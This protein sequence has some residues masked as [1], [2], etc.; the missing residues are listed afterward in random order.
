M[1]FTFKEFVKTIS[2]YRRYYAQEITTESYFGFPIEPIL[3]VEERLQSLESSTVAYLSMEFALAAGHYNSMHGS[4]LFEVANRMEPRDVVS[5]QMQTDQIVQLTID[6]RKDLPIYSGGLGVLAGDVIK[7]AADLKLPFV[8]V[9]LLWRKGFFR[10]KIRFEHGQTVEDELWD[11]RRYPGLIALKD[12]ITIESQ[13]GPI[14][15]RLWKYYVYSRDRQHACPLILLDTYIPQSDPDLKK[16]TDQLYRSDH[17]WW[18][19]A[20]R[21]VLG[22][23][24]VEALE[25][26]GYPIHR[27]HLNEG[28]AAFAF[29]QKYMDAKRNKSL[30]G[31]KFAYTCH[32][33]V[34]AGHDRFHLSDLKKIFTGRQLRLIKKFGAEQED[35]NLIN[36]TQICLSQCQRANT[37]SRQHGNISRQQFPEFKQRIQSITNGVHVPTWLS[38]SMHDLF[39]MYQKD[40]GDW[41][42]YPKYLD[43]IAKFKSNAAFRTDLFDAH[44]KSKRELV[45][46]LAPWGFDENVFTMGWARRFADYKRPQLLFEDIEHLKQIAYNEG[47]LQLIYA[48]KAHPSDEQGAG[49]IEEVLQGIDQLSVENT[50]IKVVFLE[51]YDTYLG[52]LLT[53]GVDVCLNNPLPPFEASG[54]SGMKA[55]LNGVLQLSTHDGWVLETTAKK[56][57]WLFGATHSTAGIES[58]EELKL[59]QD[60]QELYEVLQKVIRLYYSMHRNGR[61]DYSSE[62]IDRMI[63]SISVGSYFTTDRMVREY[64]QLMWET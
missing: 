54:T 23:A 35:P 11:P 2:N 36:L 20:Q 41:Q 62:W 50:N 4:V 7:T 33:S 18:Q 53:S 58:E 43:K 26:M 45:R 25:S 21:A 48:G 55:A 6:R 9:G 63:N 29:I 51:N 8:G 39:Q 34:K 57:G 15:V 19:I 14:N 59:K 32:T 28:H 31:K 5:T 49:R 38:Q 52:R 44:Q 60:S 64:L 13:Y 3:A 10:Q 37:V 30:V 47:A 17:P 42:K 46:Y 27:Y 12:K 22:C 61:V 1:T 24:S 56:I 40:I 16:I